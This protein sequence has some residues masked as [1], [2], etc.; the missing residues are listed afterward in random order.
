MSNEDE[1]AGSVIGVVRRQSAVWHQDRSCTSGARLKEYRAE[2]ARDKEGL[3]A[4]LECCPNGW[5]TD[6]NG[7]QPDA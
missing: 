2:E 4:C 5:P 3:T 7:G 1:D 6:T